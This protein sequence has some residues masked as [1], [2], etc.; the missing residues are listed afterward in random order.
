MRRV[1]ALLV[2]VGLVAGCKV[3]ARVD[4]TLR[5]DGS[6]T[7]TARVAL[8]ADAVRR[9]TPT[10]PLARAVPLGDVRAAGWKVSSWT[11]VSGGGD[12]ITLTHDFVGQADLARR[13]ADLV[14]STGVLRGPTI[15]HTRGWFGSKDTLAVTVDLRD[16]S[17]G[18]RSDAQLAKQLTFAGVDVKTLDA[19][20]RSQLGN[21]LTFTVRVQAPG[22]QSQT[23]QL[24]SGKQ[25]TVSAST[26]HTYTRRIVLGV[27]GAGLILVA[28]LLAAGSALVRSRRRRVV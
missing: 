13:L 28:L 26:S 15:T 9:L 11:A 17:T 14:G 27:T 7:V 10:E 8:D 18:L 19:Q 6:G 16:L 2:L 25:A 4:V 5:A 1:C 21:A 3:D 20:L 12:A 24:S 23:V 22:G